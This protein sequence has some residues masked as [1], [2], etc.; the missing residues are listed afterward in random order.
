MVYHV[1]NQ[2][3]VSARE[4]LHVHDV[5]PLSEEIDTGESLGVY[6]K[7]VSNMIHLASIIILNRFIF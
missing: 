6:R 5:L 4:G 3:D 7:L 2:T 1:I